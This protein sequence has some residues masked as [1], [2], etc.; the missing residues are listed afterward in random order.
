MTLRLVYT[1][2]AITIDWVKKTGCC[3]SHHTLHSNYKL[4]YFYNERNNNL[5]TNGCVVS[6]SFAIERDT[7]QSL[8]NLYEEREK[9]GSVHSINNA[10]PIK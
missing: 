3:V 10:L 9:I 6:L 4:Y 1:T 8:H 7:K 5:P 2:P